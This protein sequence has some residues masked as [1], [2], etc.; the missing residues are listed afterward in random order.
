MR[1]RHYMTA[2][3]AAQILFSTAAAHA[4]RRTAVVCSTAPAQVLNP[5]VSPD[6]AAADLRLL[7]FTPLVLYN[8]QGGFRPYLA[9][10]WTWSKDSKKLVFQIR[11]DVKWHDGKPVTAEDVAWTIMRAANREF[12]L[13]AGQEFA[14]VASARAVGATTVQI[15]FK[16]PFAAQLEPFTLLPIMPKQLLEN[17][18]PADFAKAPYHRDPI[19]SGPFKFVTRNADR[20]LV[21]ERATTFP[22]ALGRPQLNRIIMRAIPEPAAMLTEL[23][24]GN[25]D[26]CIT[27]SAIM[28]RAQKVRTL[29]VLGIPPT[30]TYALPLNA[31]RAP[32]NDAR[33]R[34]AFSAALNRSDLAFILSPVAVPARTMLPMKS[35]YIAKEFAQ[36][37][38][39]P[40]LA[41][42]L[43]DSGGWRTNGTGQRSNAAGQPLRI[44]IAGPQSHSPVLTA[45]QAQLK[46]AGFAVELRL[47][48]GATYVAL[49]QNADQRPE[50]MSLGYVP[51]R[52][53]FPDYF[54]QFHS[55]SA[56]NLAGYNNPAVDSIVEAMRVTIAPEKRRQLYRDLQRFVGSDVPTVYTAYSPR[57]AIVGQRLKGLRIGLNGPFSSLLEWSFSR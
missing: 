24:T 57:I 48:E 20:S 10:T 23:Q 30:V 27:G 47:L 38:K 29:R 44:T 13:R 56:R 19:G 50:A 8:D 15:E 17:V 11:D 54:D 32:F 46:Q 18:L 9:R 7:L 39:N 14:S 41:A 25:V 52:T 5:L 35:S 12:A 2:A 42:A 34:R 3:I 40:R 49:L 45:V 4:Q 33:V 16:Q 31:R 28:E 43:L 53:L 55:K 36:P 1:L 51:D 21:F 37:D 6:A 26:V 22:A